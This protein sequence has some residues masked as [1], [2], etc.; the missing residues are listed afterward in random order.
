MVSRQT[1]EETMFLLDLIWVIL[2]TT[3][4]GA[5]LFSTES[6]SLIAITLV[7]YGISRI[8]VDM[9]GSLTPVNLR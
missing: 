1:I 9:C 8:R 5:P 3:S 2:H 7:A 4:A 6:V